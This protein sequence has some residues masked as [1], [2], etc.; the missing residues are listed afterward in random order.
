MK[1]PGGVLTHYKKADITKREKQTLSIM[2]LGL[3]AN[4]ATQEFVDLVEYLSS[5]KKK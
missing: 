1:A 3:Q 2:P 4:L 5:L